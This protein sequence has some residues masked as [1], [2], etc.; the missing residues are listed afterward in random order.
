MTGLNWLNCAP[1]LKKRTG[2]GAYVAENLRGCCTRT[3]GMYALGQVWVS[4]IPPPQ[5]ACGIRADALLVTPSCRGQELNSCR[6]AWEVPAIAAARLS[7]AWGF[8]DV[9]DG[10]ANVKSMAKDKRLSCKG[11]VP[12]RHFFTFISQRPQWQ[13]RWRLV[14][15]L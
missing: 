4:L 6:S 10:R 15:Q 8:G 5:K 13:Q 1:S 7:E 9:R 3:H 11:P 2:S 14:P 12:Q